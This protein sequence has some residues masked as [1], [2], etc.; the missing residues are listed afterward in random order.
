MVF[1]TVFVFFQNLAD[2]VFGFLLVLWPKVSYTN[3]EVI[4]KS[5]DH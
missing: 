1:Y 5:K 3:L 2:T 4:K